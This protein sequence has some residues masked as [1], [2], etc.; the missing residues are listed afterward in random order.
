VA[1][2]PR[3]I[4]KTFAIMGSSF[5]PGASGLIDKLTNRIGLLLDLKREPKNP[6]DPNAVAI[7]WGGYKLGWVPRGLA[8]EIAPFMD[9]G[10]SVI[11]RKAAG[12]AGF[13]GVVRGVLELAYIPPEPKEVSHDNES[14]AGAPGQP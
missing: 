3:Q 11:C 5:I 13:K 4:Q 14:D 12:V 1:V 6:A 9:S 10:V 2:D 8:A 7:F